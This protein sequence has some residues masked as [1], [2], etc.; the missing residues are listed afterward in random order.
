MAEYVSGFVAATTRT[1][2]W[3][4]VA[5]APDTILLVSFPYW[6][7]N[8]FPISNGSWVQLLDTNSSLTDL[9]GVIYQHL[10]QQDKF[11]SLMVQTGLH[12]MISLVVEAVVCTNRSLCNKCNCIWRWISC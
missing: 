8:S 6:S 10:L 1:V 3:T 5:N 4:P 2:E 9:A 12:L 11:L 7:G